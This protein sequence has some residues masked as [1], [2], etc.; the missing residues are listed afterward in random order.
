MCIRT[1][2]LVLLWLQ[3]ADVYNSQNS[4]ESSETQDADTSPKRNPYRVRDNA[5]HVFELDLA[6]LK[7]SPNEDAPV[8]HVDDSVSMSFSW[9][10]HI[11][12]SSTVPGH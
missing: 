2:C 6:P 9:R 5:H 3:A 10:G 1:S 7:G 4:P 8:V 12:V 11:E